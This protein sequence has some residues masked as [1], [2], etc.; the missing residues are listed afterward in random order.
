MYNKGDLLK[1]EL[2]AI[3]AEQLAG[4]GGEGEV[5]HD[6]AGGWGRCAGK[7]CCRKRL[8][9]LLHLLAPLD[10]SAPLSWDGCKGGWLRNMAKKKK[11]RDTLCKESE[12]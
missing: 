12:I 10:A 7:E 9:K 4:E 8:A 3:G 5:G 1:P 6:G 2:A 11:A